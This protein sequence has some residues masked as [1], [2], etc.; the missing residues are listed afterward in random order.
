MDPLIAVRAIHLAATTLVAGIVFF[1]WLVAGPGLRGPGELLS[2][3][4]LR[5]HARTARILWISLGLAVMSGAAWLSL[6]AADIVDRPLLEV[7]ADGT[8]WKVFT[9]TRF[10]LD[11]Q[12]R[13]LCAVLLGGY[14][15]KSRR[16]GG[17]SLLSGLPAAA[18]A[19]AFIGAL[20]W[21]GHGGATPGNT[22][23]IHVSAD[24]LHLVAAGAWLGG[25]VPLV[26]LLG[27]V[28]RSD[29]ERRATAAGA[30]CHRFSN[31][32]IFSVGAL[33]VSGLTNASFLV[34]DAQGLT[35][36]SYGRLLM[37]KLFLFF[38]MVCVAA[39][40]RQYLLPRLA[41]GVA[42]PGPD[43]DA[44]IARLERN[45]ALE[46]AFGIAVLVVVAML[47]VAPPATEPHV[48]IH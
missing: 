8:A 16:T 21:A 47:G 14:V 43:A 27:C 42:A 7:I 40:N 9:Q 31:L 2:P 28:R 11:W 36:T 30:I 24:V 6:L 18:L 17:F 44:Q 1:E 29:G 35:G 23:I 48:H 15:Q 26:I 45:A 25:L 10:G 4:L 33:L 5:F 32:G 39:V 38:G 22:G 19:A 12:M 46:I 13:L 3:I 20:A 41:S 37:L 34:G